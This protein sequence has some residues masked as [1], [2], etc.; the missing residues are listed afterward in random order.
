MKEKSYLKFI[1]PEKENSKQKKVD[2]NR[3][4]QNF[5]IELVKSVRLTMPAFIL[6]LLVLIS[7][8]MV[9]YIGVFCGK[10]TFLLNQNPPDRN[11][12]ASIG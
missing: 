1:L 7:Q 12:L 10:P 9:G 6:L 3:T 8:L 5:E 11:L 4:E 2:T